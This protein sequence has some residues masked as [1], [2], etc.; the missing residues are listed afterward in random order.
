MAPQYNRAAIIPLKPDY[1]Q[2]AIHRIK[3]AQTREIAGVTEK[4]SVEVPQLSEQA[5]TYELL[6]F[7]R[8]FELARATMSWTTGPKLYE[9]FI[10]HL[11]G[12]HRQT[13][14]DEAAGKAQ[15]VATFDQTILEF[16]EQ[17]LENKDYDNQMD[18]IRDLH[19]PQDMKPGTFLLYLRIQNSMVQELPGAPLADPGFSDMQLR[20]IYLHAMPIAWQSTFEDANKSV[21]DTPLNAMRTYFDKQHAKDPYKGQ[22]NKENQKKQQNPESQNSGKTNRNSGGRNFQ[23]GGRGAGRGRGGCG[24]GQ[25]QQGRIQNGNPCP[26][27]GHAGHTWG[28]CHANKFADASQGS[29]PGGNYAAR[30]GRGPN[31]DSH[32]NESPRHS[33]TNGNPQAPT[34]TKPTGTKQESFFTLGCVTINSNNP[35]SYYDTQDDLEIKHYQPTPVKTVIS[36]PLKLRAKYPVTFEKVEPAED[37]LDMVPTTLSVARKVNGNEGRYFFKSLFDSGGTSVMINKRASRYP[38]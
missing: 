2:S 29:Q 26:L 7:L 14:T 15:T 19:K 8:E 37:K 6:T 3:H 28:Q 10:M 25:G 16:K 34:E 35:E 18:Y 27:P 9:K 30:P 4:T 5:G 13:W 12:Y 1:E 22:T 32:T 33:N 36:K 24:Q 38:I 21:A 23:R 31:R 11:Q 20:R 17:L